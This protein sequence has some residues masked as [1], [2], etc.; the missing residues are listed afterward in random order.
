MNPQQFMETKLLWIFVLASSLA[1]CSG[2]AP[3]QKKPL[4]NADVL[5]MAKAGLAEAV[6][7]AAIQSNPGNYD[8]SPTA[9]IDL[10]K[11]GVSAKVQ[12]AMLAA[13]KPSQTAPS[14]NA[15]V[16]YD[17]VVESRLPGRRHRTDGN[18]TEQGRV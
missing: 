3:A 5:Q 16:G 18:E 13:Q 6:I 1:L 7:V 12:E 15:G 11:E 14:A 4:T 17:R 10:N 2:Q 9:L 8:T